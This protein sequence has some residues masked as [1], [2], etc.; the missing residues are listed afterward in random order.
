MPSQKEYPILYSFRRCP[1][2]MRARMSLV[3]SGIEVQLRE[4]ILRNKPPSMLAYS[5]KGTVPVLIVNSPESSAERVIDESLDVMLW[6]LTQQDSDDL[7]LAA[8]ANLRAEA[9][10]LIHENDTSFKQNLDRYKYSVRH[11]EQTQEEY[12][13]QG[14]TF[15]QTLE[16]RLQQNPYLLTNRM[17]LADIAICP[18]IRQF[19]NVDK[20]WFDQ[21][22]YPRLRAWLEALLTSSLFIQAMKKYD[23]WQEGDELVIFPHCTDTV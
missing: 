23:L 22:P 3:Y 6:A 7:L 9:D 19:A 11:P 12:R 17:T 14:E 16:D 10:A 5:P 8:N 15:L 13:T 21:A 20:A 4:I 2:A 1:Y 18:F